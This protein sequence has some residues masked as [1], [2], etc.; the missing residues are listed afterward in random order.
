L[1]AAKT[2]PGSPSNLR[3]TNPRLQVDQNKGLRLKKSMECLETALR[4]PVCLWGRKKT[5]H[6]TVSGGERFVWK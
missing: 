1:A 6:T 5:P 2:G 4:H 3:G